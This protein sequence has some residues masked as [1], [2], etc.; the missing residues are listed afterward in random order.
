[1]TALSGRP[2][3]AAGSRKAG[4]LLR[5]RNAVAPEFAKQWVW[6]SEPWLYPSDALRDPAG[7]IAVVMTVYH[8]Y[9]SSIA[10][11]V[12]SRCCRTV[13]VQTV[14]IIRDVRRLR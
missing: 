1:M 5:H 7:I 8:R 2:V 14:V 11:S 9:K 13:R 6:R 4:R 3:S 12:M 10:R